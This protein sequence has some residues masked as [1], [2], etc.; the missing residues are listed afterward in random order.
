V[1][2]AHVIYMGNDINDIPCFPL[3]GYAV[4]PADA[5]PE[6]VRQADRVLARRGGH[7]AVREFCDLLLQKAGER[8]RQ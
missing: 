7:G 4:T 3:V 1:D 5:E 6:A 2:P 8:N